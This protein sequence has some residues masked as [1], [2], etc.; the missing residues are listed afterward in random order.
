MTDKSNC[1]T[2]PVG[3]A[4]IALNSTDVPAIKSYPVK[5]LK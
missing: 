4:T 1:S 5:N 3:K 2:D